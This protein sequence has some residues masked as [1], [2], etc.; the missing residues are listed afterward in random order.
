M[1]AEAGLAHAAI[2]VSDGLV[3]DLGHIC[4]TS[5]LGAEVETGR[6][7]LSTAAAAALSGQPELMARILTGGDDYEILFTAPPGNL[8]AVADLSRRLDLPLTVIGRMTAGSGVR[9]VGADGAEI[10]LHSAGYRHF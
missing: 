8:D 1:L 3:A 2:D 5:G 4:E 7:P 10:A 9:V 6:L